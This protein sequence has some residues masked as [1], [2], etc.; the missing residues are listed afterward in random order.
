MPKITNKHSKF[1][2]STH[3]IAKKS[4]QIHT[5]IVYWDWNTDGTCKDRIHSQIPELVLW[6]ITHVTDFE[7]YALRTMHTQANWVFIKV[8]NS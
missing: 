5:I 6:T 4:Y 2:E 8:I 1:I 7:M 3:C